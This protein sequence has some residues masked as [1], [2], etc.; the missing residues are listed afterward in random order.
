MIEAIGNHLP[1]AT[2]HGA[3]AGLHLTITFDDPDLTDLALASA[4]LDRGVKTSR[5]PGT[6]STLAL[7]ASSSATPPAPRPRSLRLSR[8]SA[9]RCQPARSMRFARARRNRR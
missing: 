7:Q 4:T 6:A 3:A 8:R 1:T 9:K 2:V 5:C